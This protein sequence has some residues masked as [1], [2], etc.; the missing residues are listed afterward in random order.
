M[1]GRGRRRRR[2]GDF[3]TGGLSAR[4]A[5][6]ARSPSRILMSADDTVLASGTSQTVGVRLR[7]LF[8]LDAGTSGQPC[9]SVAVP[10]AGALPA[11]GRRTGRPGWSRRSRPTCGVADRPDAGSAPWSASWHGPRCAAQPAPIRDA[12]ERALVGTKL[13]SM[14]Q[15]LQRSV[16]VAPTPDAT[17]SSMFGTGDP[18]RDWRWCSPE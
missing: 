9:R 7:R 4:S 15:S 5:H 11:G 3:A 18:G 10:L 14:G 2:P 8:A 13:R 16:A 17:R 6:S 12:R 1:H